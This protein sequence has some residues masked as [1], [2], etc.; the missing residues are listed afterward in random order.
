MVWYLPHDPCRA[1]E[2]SNGSVLVT[3]HL[4]HSKPRHSSVNIGGIQAPRI[5]IGVS[6]SGFVGLHL[7]I[8]V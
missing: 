8:R 3:E 6:S 4:D 2:L 5:G 1:I 7:R